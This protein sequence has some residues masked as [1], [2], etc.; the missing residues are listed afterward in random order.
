MTVAVTSGPWALPLSNWQM[1]HLPL[2]RTT[3]WGL[4]LKYHGNEYILK[5]VDTSRI[6]SSANNAIKAVDII[7]CL[8]GSFLC[9]IVNLGGVH[10]SISEGSPVL[11][12]DL[13]PRLCRLIRYV[14]TELQE[15]LFQHVLIIFFIGAHRQQW[16][17]RQSVRQL[18]TILFPSKERYILMTTETL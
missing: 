10:R 11:E 4:C 5:R 3:R 1:A 16:R 14:L 2:Q 6:C 17:T 13:I 15:T 9:H 18:S 12:A 8:L 7:Y